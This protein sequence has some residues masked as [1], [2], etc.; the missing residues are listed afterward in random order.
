MKNFDI[1]I[2]SSDF[3]EFTGEGLL[4]R[5]FV[6]NLFFK[7]NK[8]KIITNNSIVFFNKKNFIKKKKKYKNNFISKYFFLFYGIFLIWFYHLKEKK[9]VY[10]NYLP[11]WNFV[12]FFLLPAKTLLG[13]ITGNI[14]KGKIHNF[15]SFIRKNIF[16]LLYFISIKIIFKKYKKLIF[17][18]ENLKKI[19]PFHFKRNCIFNFCFLFYKKRKLIKKNIDFIFY[20]KKHPLKANDFHEFLIK[21]LAENGFNII[22]VG[23]KFS[24]KNVVNYINIPREQLLSLLDRTLYAVS[25]ADNFYSLFLLDCMSC[26]V[27]LFINKQ[28]KPKKPLFSNLLYTFLNFDNFNSSFKQILFTINK[29]TSK[30]SK[31]DNDHNFCTMQNKIKLELNKFNF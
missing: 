22:V 7:K 15:N 2:W 8:I 20:L 14:Y 18:T 3:E 4:S 27:K 29:K 12:I 13:P 5:C 6:D 16:P 9:T 25:P 21:K 23:D 30:F 11:L 31:K 1:F 17:S 10:I 26:N 24:Y 19:I 28:L